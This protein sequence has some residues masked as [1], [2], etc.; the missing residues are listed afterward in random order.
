[1]VSTFEVHRA[2]R[3]LWKGFREGTMVVCWA[4]TPLVPE[5]S[6][7]WC[8]R[9]EKLDRDDIS[10]FWG[11]ALQPGYFFVEA[12]N[13]H[14]WSPDV[15]LRIVF[16]F[17][18]ANIWVLKAR[19]KLMLIK[20][21]WADYS[22]F[23]CLFSWKC[24]CWSQWKGSSWVWH[25]CWVRMALLTFAWA[26]ACPVDLCACLRAICHLSERNGRQNCSISCCNCRCIPGVGG[27]ELNLPYPKPWMPLLITKRLYKCQFPNYKEIY[28]K[29]FPIKLWVYIYVVGWRKT[30]FWNLK[31]E[32][33]VKPYK[34]DLDNL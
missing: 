28:S 30:S 11:L 1:M 34:L 3:E 7:C 5:T 18:L 25:P 26:N 22:M 15:W 6:C 29:P 2:S 27:T 16:F 9:R 23:S 20:T 14:S 33:E 4:S 10:S 13:S 31:A 21:L 24:L 19:N 32:Q 12:F 8:S 17:S